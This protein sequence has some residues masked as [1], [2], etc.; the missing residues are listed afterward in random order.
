[1]SS[2]V[3]VTPTNPPLTFQFGWDVLNECYYL[4][5]FRRLGEDEDEEED[6]G[7]ECVFSS[8]DCVNNSHPCGG[9]SLAQ[10]RLMLD[11]FGIMRGHT[12]YELRI[13]TDLN[14]YYV[15]ELA[16]VHVSSEPIIVWRRSAGLLPCE[17]AH[18]MT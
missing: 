10:L 6:A 15:G 13:S 9:L 17:V 16:Q 2:Y 18:S 11:G 7:E 8:V 14:D 3:Y 4:V 5:V 1:M 12:K